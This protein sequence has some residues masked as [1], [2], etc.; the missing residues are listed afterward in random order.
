MTLH[1]NTIHFSDLP[2]EC[3]T[4]IVNQIP[5]RDLYRLLTVNR[6]FFKVVVRKLYEDPIKVLSRYYEVQS[7]NNAKA[8]Q[9]LFSLLARCLPAADQEIL[10]NYARMDRPAPSS[11]RPYVPYTQL[12]QT[13][14]LEHDLLLHNPSGLVDLTDRIY[15][16]G[17]HDLANNLVTY[18]A[19]FM[20][21]TRGSRHQWQYKEPLSSEANKG[22]ISVMEEELRQA[23]DFFVALAAMQQKHRQSDPANIV[24]RRASSSIAPKQLDA[25]LV[26][27][28][29]PRYY[30]SIL[31]PL[32]RFFK[33]LPIIKA[34]KVL[35]NTG[36]RCDYG[37]LG[38]SMW[39]R[40]YASPY[41][42][43]LGMIEELA[44]WLSSADTDLDS[45][46]P[47]ENIQRILRQ[48][49]S[50]KLLSLNLDIVSSDVFEWAVQESLFTR[51][52]VQGSPPLPRVA[53]QELNLT[54]SHA[55]PMRK[56]IL[57]AAVA[58]PSLCTLKIIWPKDE[59]KDETLDL[60]GLLT[61][62]NLRTLDVDGNKGVLWNSA[63]FNGLPHLKHL[64]LDL[65]KK[66]I[67]HLEPCIMD[68]LES[69][70]LIDGGACSLF[71]PQTIASMTQLR[72]LVI[73]CCVMNDVQ[74]WH[75][76]WAFPNLEY[77]YLRR[78]CLKGFHIHMVGSSKCPK[79]TDLYVNG[80]TIVDHKLEDTNLSSLA[81]FGSLPSVKRLVLTSFRPTTKGYEKVLSAHFPN[82]QYFA[83]TQ[84]T[85]SEVLRG[86]ELR[87]K[88]YVEK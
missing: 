59:T 40:F 82:L 33:L 19:T 39:H 28:V 64:K 65:G 86:K 31:N 43:N 56:V 20:L 71:H 22:L 88:Y 63:I 58:F 24:H 77:L 37:S 47:Q 68:G 62:P 81:P 61:F 32:R 38:D 35:G 14:S 44:P 83:T 30:P 52:V 12:I 4:L 8:L 69:L 21:S 70:E 17:N 67:E 41:S 85:T 7:K 55:L 75:Q 51:S 79:L 36:Y 3:L 5:L 15:Q 26:G 84:G 76:E 9:A 45:P 46:W 78:G 13:L 1:S 48:C 53:L 34:R 87:K 25:R 60:R 6:A 80:S 11:G 10:Y 50:L 27:Y 42:F 72:R 74:F 16:N 54:G 29:P 73:N 66:V 18:T 49:R 57:D 2:P 23:A